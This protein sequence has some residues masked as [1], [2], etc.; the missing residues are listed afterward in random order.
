MTINTG[1]GKGKRVYAKWKRK[2]VG[3]ED[4]DDGED[5]S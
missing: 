5:G 1:Y 4:A 3:G 2:E